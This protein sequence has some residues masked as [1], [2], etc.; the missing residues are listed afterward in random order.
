MKKNL[1]LLDRNPVD[2]KSGQWETGTRL[3]KIVIL[4]MCS[5]CFAM[6]QSHA[7]QFQVFNTENSGLPHNQVQS[8]AIDAQ[9]NKW[10]GTYYGEVVKFDDVNWT[11]YNKHNS[12]IPGNYQITTIAVD[13]QDNKWFGASYSPNLLSGGGLIKF[14]NTTWTLYNV[15]NSGLPHNTVTD[16]AID[17]SG[18]K[19]ISTNG[20]GVAKFDN[21]SW[22]VYNSS[23]SGLPDDKVGSISIDDQGNKWVS[24][25]TAIA[26]Y[27]GT[28]WTI[29]KYS[30]S[31]IPYFN[32]NGGI[33]SVNLDDK[34]NKWFGISP[35][36]D[37]GHPGGVVKFDDKNWTVYT[38][39]NSDLPYGVLSAATD[40]MGDIWFAA[41][42][43]SE[44]ALVKYN[45]SAWTVYDSENSDFPDDWINSV[46]IDEHGTKWF[47]TGNSGVVKFYEARITT[48]MNDHP[49]ARDGFTVYPNPAKDQISINALKSG[50]LMMLN[51]SG[52]T[53]KKLEVIGTPTNVDI[54]GLPEGIYFIRFITEDNIMV[55]KIIKG[56]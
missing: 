50:T 7:Q 42:S 36:W 24:T 9:G 54:S 14:D 12:E 4:T 8:V 37:T 5:W 6:L 26:K 20:G 31:I 28:A 56:N 34:G 41:S 3:F 44:G 51:A 19:W 40:K 47:V 39:T 55:E 18:N 11:V 45:G 21:N 53:I 27:D 23:N 1:K 48:G 16:I 29:Y 33:T 2:L 32:D 35:D 25:M 46:V 30:T 43:W 15:S 52:Q 17:K 49:L 22:T 10:F 38:N 13:A